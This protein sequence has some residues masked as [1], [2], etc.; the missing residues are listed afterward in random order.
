MVLRY[1]EEN[2]ASEDHDDFEDAAEIT[3]EVDGAVD[4][5]IVGFLE[6]LQ[7]N[8]R[9]QYR[10]LCIG[11]VFPV[12]RQTEERIA[13]VKRGFVTWWAVSDSEPA[14]LGRGCDLAQRQLRR[15]DIV[16][17]QQPLI[18]DLHNPISWLGIV[19]AHI[20]LL[21]NGPRLNRG[22]LE[23]VIN[24]FMVSALLLRTRGSL[25]R[26][27]A[28]LNLKLDVLHLL[29]SIFAV[30]LEIHLLEIR[31]DHGLAE[32]GHFLEERDAFFV[33]AE[34]GFLA[35]LRQHR[36]LRDLV[37]RSRPIF[38][39]LI[40]VQFNILHY[41]LIYENWIGFALIFGFGFFGGLVLLHRRQL[42]LQLLDFIILLGR[43]RLSRIAIAALEIFLLLLLGQ[44][45]S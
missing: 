4:C 3:E 15:I 27:D 26:C 32:A 34:V 10:I 38:A 33:A 12:D 35:L 30:E 24:L 5:A 44:L 9:E 7:V 29:V 8:V 14:D 18:H 6:R 1:R 11:T 28:L 23:P 42:L 2:D 20:D 40:E 31:A 41:T 36:L 39:Q 43:V 21:L 25:R 37:L 45:V 13:I 22:R 17:T 19:L 16:Y